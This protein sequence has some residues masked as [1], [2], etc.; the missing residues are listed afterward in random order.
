MKNYTVIFIILLSLLLVSCRQDKI[1]IL[2]EEQALNKEIDLTAWGVY[3]DSEGASSEMRYL[4]EQLDGISYFAAYFDQYNQLFIPENISELY[5]SSK[6][7]LGNA[8][9]LHYLSVV[10]D[11]INSDGSSSLKDTALLYSLLA[12]EKL[13]KEHI[14]NLAKLTLENGYDGLEID[15]EGIKKDEA[16]WGYFLEFVSDLYHEANLQGLKLRVVLEPSA[17]IDR[18]DFP[19]GPDYVIMCYNLYGSHS[20]PGPKADIKFL[21]ELSDRMKLLP[22]EVNFAL[23]TGGFDWDAKGNVRSLTEEGAV[24]LMLLYESEPVRD[25]ESHSLV[26]KYTDNDRIEHE[27]WFA[28]EATLTQWIKTLWDENNTKF[29]LWRL[30]GNLTRSLNGLK[31]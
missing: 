25:K 12:D 22:S 26:F 16:L 15:Y 18:Y 1:D 28:D 30:G 31:N 13:R 3:W 2:K 8:E 24:E 23:S 21:Q 4:K 11:K 5:K 27:V 7:A 20:G 29:S 19:E 9:T 17:P 6:E 14:N 10:N